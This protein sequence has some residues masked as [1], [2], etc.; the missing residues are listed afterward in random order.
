MELYGAIPYSQEF[1]A[2]PYLLL[3]KYSLHSHTLYKVTL[4]YC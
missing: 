4:N 1:F 3:N 2:T